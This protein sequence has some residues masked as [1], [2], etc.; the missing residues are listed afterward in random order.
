MK[1]WI[2]T[3]L[4]IFALVLPAVALA[5]ADP[6][7]GALRTFGDGQVTIKGW[8][9]TIKND[10]GEHGGVYSKNGPK[11][12]RLDQVK[13]KFKT[14]G[15]VQG[16]AP[17]WSIPIDVSGDQ[18]QDGYAFLDAANCGATVG[19]NDDHVVTNVSTSN[20]D[21][22][23]FFGPD[24]WANWA[25][26]AAAKPDYRVAKKDIPFIIADGAAGHYHLYDLLFG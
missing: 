17:R 3:A 23:V 24:E 20:P 14:D 5:G 15:D 2:L 4:A 10:P 16:G 7:N 13:F 11:K 19:T 18:H 9:A 1:K 6:T 12:S 21:C 8:S 26:F 25:A 22:K